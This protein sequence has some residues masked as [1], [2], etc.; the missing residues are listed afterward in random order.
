MQ[1]LLVEAPGQ[2]TRLLTALLAESHQVRLLA[3][4]VHTPSP[5]DG[6]DEP[7]Q[8]RVERVE[9]DLLDPEAVWRAM[10]GV[11]AVVH[12]GELPAGATDAGPA[13]EDL[14]D[15]FTRGT[16]V[17]LKA[18][19]EAGVRRAV[20][21]STLDLFQG[22]PEDVY[23]TEQWRP[24]PAP[25]PA[26][27]ARYLAEQV[28]R[29]FVRD[30]RLTGTVL[31]LGP[32]TAPEEAVGAAPGLLWLDGR[33]AAAAFAMA[34]ERDRSEEVRWTSRWQVLHIC[35]D[36]PNPQF[37]TQAAARAGWVPRH[38][39]SGADSPDEAVDR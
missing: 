1:V 8:R 22:Y 35:G 27:M 25:E 39:L 34:L 18:A 13:P 3:T 11:D 21:G 26:P 23:I 17:L 36:S 28:L 32:L 2:L 10:R 38:G 24:R 14:L 33:D 6:L 5:L 7:L 37:L 9:G 31:R 29:E 16:H 20:L 30:F 12:T 19:V 15:W 4:S